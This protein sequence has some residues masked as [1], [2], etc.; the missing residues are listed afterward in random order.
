[1]TDFSTLELETST[2]WETMSDNDTRRLARAIAD[3]MSAPKVLALAG[4]LG[5][6][7]TTFVKGFVTELADNPVDVRSPTFTLINEYPSTTPSVVHAD[8]Y[9]TETQFEQETI[10]LEDYFRSGITIVEWA[11]RWSGSW[12]EFT[13]LLRFRYLEADQTRRTIE[14]D[15]ETPTDISPVSATVEGL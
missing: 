8:L 5:S 14:W 13:S 11:D 1:M 12:P 4:S 7:K 2:S 6:G 9:R 3:N 10:G 15:P